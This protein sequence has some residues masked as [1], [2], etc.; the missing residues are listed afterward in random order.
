VGKEG[1]ETNYYPSSTVSHTQHGSA[2]RQ[3]AIVN[4][5]KSLITFYGKNIKSLNGS[6]AIILLHSKAFIAYFL[7][8]M[9]GRKELIQTYSEVLKLF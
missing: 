2:D 1:L 7:G 5:Y 3:F 8:R 4:I 6:I 9:V